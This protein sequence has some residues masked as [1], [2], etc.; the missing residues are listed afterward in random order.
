MSSADDLQ[1]W[2]GSI[3][4]SM[5][6]SQGLAEIVAARLPAPTKFLMRYGSSGQQRYDIMHF[7][8]REDA[9][10]F[11]KGNMVWSTGEAAN[12]RHL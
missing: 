7:S 2:V 6:E 8:C 1:L 11:M 9:I 12:A 4:A 3:P 5:T 10:D